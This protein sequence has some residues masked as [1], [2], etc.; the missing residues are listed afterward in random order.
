MPI[1]HLPFSGS[2]CIKN[3]SR[4]RIIL[5]WTIVCGMQPLRMCYIG[6]TD[7]VRACGAVGS[8]LPWHGRGR[9][10]ESHQVHQTFQTLTN[11]K[12]TNLHQLGPNWVQFRSNLEVAR[13]GSRGSD[14]RHVFD[15]VSRN[16]RRR[17]EFS[18]Y[19]QIDEPPHDLFFGDLVGM[20]AM[21]GLLART[22]YRETETTKSFLYMQKRW[23]PSHRS[24]KNKFA[25]LRFFLDAPA[26]P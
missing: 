11:S 10:F 5:R 19:M 4:F 15:L 13:S 18:L 2:S 6:D 23:P 9:G 16:R 24:P 20:V 17:H 25:R 1:Q 8:A 14:G 21:V 7:P 22:L 12:L 3:K 26:G